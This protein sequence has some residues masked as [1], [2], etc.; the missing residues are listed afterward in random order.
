MGNDRD[1]TEDAKEELT[2]MLNEDEM[3]DAVLLVF[4][5]KQDLPNAMTAAEVTEKLGLRNLRHRRWS[6]R[7][8]GLAFPHFVQ[9]EI[10]ALLFTR[11]GTSSSE[12]DMRMHASIGDSPSVVMSRQ[13]VLL[14]FVQTQTLRTGATC[15]SKKK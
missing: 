4:A 10:D 8:P 5:N 1:R 2:K 3:R 15:H 12:G 6:L 11:K 14:F 9:Q 7:R 13:Q